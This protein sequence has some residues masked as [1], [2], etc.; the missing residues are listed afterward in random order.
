MELD[1]RHL[2]LLVAVADHGSVSAA[3]RALGLQQPTVSTQLRRVEDALGSPV[4]D[5]TPQGVRVTERGTAVLGRARSILARVDDIAPPPAAPS[6]DLLRVRT[7]VLP[8]EV[9]LPL[10]APLAPAVRWEV[11][12]GGLASGLAAVAAGRADLYFG[13]WFTGG[14]V[15]DGLVLDELVH[16]RAWVLLPAGHRCA[17]EPSVPLRALAG[18]TF[19]S[20]PEP[21]LHRALLQ[22]CRRAG[23]E[24]DVRFRVVDDSALRTVVGRGAGVALSSPLADVDEQVVLRPCPDAQGHS[25][26]LAYRPDRFPEPFLRMLTDLVRWAYAFRARANPEL[27]AALGPEAFAVSFPEPYTAS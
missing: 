22:N 19:V 7:F 18:E 3:A 12:A 1:I 24:P 14:P 9:F 10:L 8:F 25:W 17:L 26:L 11:R 20:R 13:L 27:C 21:E 2:R 5:R 4:F 6:L 15:P 23:F 16:D